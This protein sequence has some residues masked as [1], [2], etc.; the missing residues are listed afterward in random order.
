MRAAAWT[1]AAAAALAVAWMAQIHEASWAADAWAV[2]R[3]LE[4]AADAARRQA[5]T[6]EDLGLGAGAAA[7]AA[8]ASGAAAAAATAAAAAA[9]AAAALLEETAVEAVE[10]AGMVQTVDRGVVQVV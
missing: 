8:A 10:R 2:A 4:K 6:V 9:R 5:K 1:E 7:A 3:A